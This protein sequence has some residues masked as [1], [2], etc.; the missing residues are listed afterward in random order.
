[1]GEFARAQ[2]A[3]GGIVRGAI[4]ESLASGN[5]GVNKDLHEVV[6]VGD[7]FERKRWMMEEADA[8]LIF[9]GGFGTLD[10]ALEVITWKSL[11]CHAKP[12]L[13]VNL[14]GF[15]QNLISVFKEF[16]RAGMIRPGGLD[17]YAVCNTLDETWKLLDGI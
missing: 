6:L 2:I 8:F 5:E 12:I 13:F 16:E 9:P 14:K 7:L 15:W 17:L 11:H 10:E 4:T 3:A 1:M